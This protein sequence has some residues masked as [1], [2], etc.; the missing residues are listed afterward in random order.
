MDASSTA[1]T[2]QVVVVGGGVS[3]LTAAYQI[4][5]ERPDAQV[6]VLERE[7]RA[8]GTATTDVIAGFELDRGPNGFLTNLP[9]ALE[10]SVE[11]GLAGELQPASQAAQAR[12]LYAAGRLEFVPTGVMALLRS[13]LLPPAAKL[14]MALEPFV[15]TA[16]PNEDESVHAFAARRLGLA[17]ADAFVVPML[18][19]VTAGDAREVSLGAQF[20]RLHRLEVEHGSLVRGML[21]QRRARRAA[22][23][24]AAAGHGEQLASPSGGPAGP[25][26]R[27]TS[28]RSG[29]VGRLTQALSE[30]LGERVRTG[31]SVRSVSRSS[32]G[33]RVHTADGEAL[34][35]DRIIVATPAFASAD[36]LDPLAPEAAALLRT[37]PYVGV[38]VVALAYPREAVPHLLG[39]F[40]FLV[41]PGQ[42]VRALGVLWTSSSFPHQAP[43]GQVLLR[44]LGGGAR[45]PGFLELSEGEAVAAACEDLRRSLG[46]SA[47]PSLTHV[48]SWSRGI[49]QYTLGHRRRVAAIMDSA[50]RV[51]GLSLT[52]NAYHGLGLNDC[53]RDA[54]MVGRRVAAGLG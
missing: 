28:F 44:L 53:V 36:L 48:V 45:D 34:P 24:R 25:G 52:G 3:G 42:H 43:A 47:A 27:L 33:L 12:F 32:G 30:A 14:R 35:A 46:I 18:A 16:D 1:G 23:R 31:V 17:F 8:G 6:T 4:V 9:D 49:P 29:G 54:R 22:A 21:A 15:P 50:E 13:R 11:L 2:P 7:R 5:R 41:L 51:P 10:L 38:R 40:G 20:P 26:G 37:I 39:G 19:G